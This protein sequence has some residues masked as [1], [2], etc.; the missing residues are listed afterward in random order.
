MIVQRSLGAFPLFPWSFFWILMGAVSSDVPGQF[1]TVINV[2]PDPAPRSIRSHTQLNVFDGGQLFAGFDA[3]SVEFTDVDAEVNILGGAVGNGFTAHPGSTVLIAGGLIGEDFLARASNVSITG[4]TIGS[5]L[6]STDSTIAV[7]GGNLGQRFRV[8][9]GAATVSGGSF[10]RLRTDGDGKVTL[11]GSDFRLDGLP[12]DG[13][14][15]EGDSISL[16][17][18]DKFL[19]TGTLADGTPFSLAYQDLD[20]IAAG[21]LT[22]ETKLLP[23]IGAALITAS[24]D[25]VPLGVRQGQTLRVDESGSLPDNFNAGMGSTINVEHGGTVG[26]NL[27]IVGAEMTMSGGT[28][29]DHFDAFDGSRVTIS[30]GT[31]G[32][33]FEAHSGSSVTV[34]R[35]SIGETFRAW[36][37]ST[38]ALLG[39]SIGET[40]QAW[41]DSNVTIAGGAFGDGFDA[42]SD[43]TITIVGSEF[44]VDGAIVDG[45]EV[46]G[47]TVSLDVSGAVLSGILADGTPYAFSS[48]DGDSIAR[49]VLTLQASALPPAGAPLITVPTDPIPLGI[50]MG[51]TLRVDDGGVVPDNFNAGLGARVNIE[52]GGTVGDNF[53]AVGAAV[54]VAGGTVGDH[55]SVWNGGTVDIVGGEIGERFTA[56]NDIRVTISGG[57]VGDHFR[58][59]NGSEVNI[60]GGSFGDFFAVEPGSSV[61]I[62]G[63]SIGDHSDS[64]RDTA[65]TMMD[66]AIGNGFAARGTVDI[67]GGNVDTRFEALSGSS[68]TIFGGKI[69][70]Q[71][72]AHS[73]SEIHLL[74]RE[75][76]L[77]GQRV[78]GLPRPGDSIVVAARGASVLAGTLLDGNTFS[79]NLNASSGFAD[80]LFDPDATLRLTLAFPRG[81]CD[82]DENG[83]CESVD[84]DLLLAEIGSS[85]GSFD[86]NSDGVVDF[87]DTEVWLTSAGIENTGRSYLAGDANLDGVVD[88]LDLNVVG[89]HWQSP[90]TSWSQGDFNGD[91]RVDVMDLNQL[92]IN[93]HQ[94]AP[95]SRTAAVPEPSGLAWT[96]TGLLVW[97]R[98]KA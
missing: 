21:T 94:T 18:L 90:V 25:P 47:S 73:G 63:G 56:G 50:R 95:P 3:G 29:G 79:F 62:S 74:G 11:L 34:N 10:G 2:P 52:A 27:E 57:L 60:S 15:S 66:G 77:D 12:V 32:N 84:V 51:Q 22:L 4:G 42:K 83:A 64:F 31:V 40:F 96:L 65:V 1:T 93:W 17:V 7:S 9:G 49:G 26:S 55:S 70:R 89:I 78:E 92:G 61:T 98:R 46:E 6:A 13:L 16:D 72:K 80:D 76:S 88:A 86:L 53:E 85:N 48:Q 59:R 38:V 81:F 41:S 43:S 82:F 28:V 14:D 19:L 44:R 33:V 5:F 71:F 8:L 75:F 91:G 67:F 45:L 37:G 30:G 23:P 54:R 58:V 87:A 35:G 39:G 68:V 69:G 97:T 24:T 36:G 20:V